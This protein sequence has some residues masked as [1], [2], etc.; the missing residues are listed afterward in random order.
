[1]RRWL[2]RLPVIGIACVAV[3]LGAGQAQGQTTATFS[4]AGNTTWVCPSG[5]T[6]VQVE[7]WGGGGGGGGVSGKFAAAGGAAGGSYVEY[8]M[9][10][11]PGNTY[12]ITVGAA[13]SA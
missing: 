7:S 3:G 13:G 4:T 6:S 9:S 12:Q 11:T 10:V 5:V 1:M 2:G 8:T